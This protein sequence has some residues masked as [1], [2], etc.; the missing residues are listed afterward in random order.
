MFR[1][2]LIA[3]AGALVV[4]QVAV[5]DGEA[6]GGDREGAGA[7]A[8]ERDGGERGEGSGGDADSGGDAETSEPARPAGRISDAMLAR[9]DDAD[10]HVR[11]GETVALLQDEAITLA[12]IERAYRRAQSLEQRR[13]LMTVAEH[14]LLRIEQQ[15]LVK[16]E[17]SDRAVVTSGASVGLSQAGVPAESEPGLEQPAIRVMQTFPGFPGHAYLQCGDLIVA[18]DGKRLRSVA[19]EEGYDHGLALASQFGEMVKAHQPG[20]QITMELLRS[21]KKVKVTFRL[22]SYSALT[23]L[24]E[25]SE[26]PLRSPYR[27]KWAEFAYELQREPMSDGGDGSGDGVADEGEGGA[28]L[29]AA[30]RDG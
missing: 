29:G 21:G 10:Y 24:Y 28:Y 25:A 15:Q 9:L 12:E 23:T 26:D 2:L 13:R 1:I 18:V 27:E 11:E 22:S 19:V 3:L 7:R 4:Q 5:A 16:E 8:A 30:P 6:V 20:E 17:L 14:H